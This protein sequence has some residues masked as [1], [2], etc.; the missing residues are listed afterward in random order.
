M[1]KDEQ[2]DLSLKIM[3]LF[4]ALLKDK[5]KELSYLHLGRI[6]EALYHVDNSDVL[7]KLEAFFVKEV[8]KAKY[9]NEGFEVALDFWRREVEQEK[10]K[11]TWARSVLEETSRS[12]HRRWVLRAVGLIRE[13]PEFDISKN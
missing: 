2:L 11:Q 9:C 13:L 12:V 3:D 4:F 7:G 10:C 1:V 8:L 5:S 6:V